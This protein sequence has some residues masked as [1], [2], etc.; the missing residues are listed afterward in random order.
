MKTVAVNPHSI[1]SGVQI[2]AMS[3]PT[4][5]VNKIRAIHMDGAAFTFPPLDK[6]DS[7][8][9]FL[10]DPGEAEAAAQD[11]LCSRMKETRRS[12]KHAH[13]CQA[14]F[15]ALTRAQPAHLRNRVNATASTPI[16]PPPPPP[17]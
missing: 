15:P 14:A 13:T 4:A 1:R 10:C 16:L 12:E 9:T 3:A 11:A 7:H 8:R 2:V 17:R 6:Q 5:A